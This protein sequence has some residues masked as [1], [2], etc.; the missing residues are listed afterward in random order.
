MHI[1]HDASRGLD[2]RIA[3]PQD[4]YLQQYFSDVAS[5]LRVGP[6]VSF[7]VK[8]INITST[9]YIQRHGTSSNTIMNKNNT[10]LDDDG[11][12]DVDKICSIAGC[13]ED[14]L[15]NRISYA[16]RRPW[17]SF[18]ASPA[19][20]WLDDFL[21]W[22]SPEIPQCCRIFPNSTACP[23]PDQPPCMEYTTQQSTGV[24]DVCVPCFEAK[25]QEYLGLNAAT[26]P[27]TEGFIRRLPQFMASTPSVQCSK[28]GM[29][30][31]T[32][33]LQMGVDDPTG[34]AGLSDG[35]IE[36]SYFQTYYVPLSHQGDF[37]SALQSS[38]N[39]AQKA[40]HELGMDIFAYS[41]FHVFFE[42]YLTLGG[43]ALAM[44]G[45]AAVA[46]FVMTL[47]ATGSPWAASIILTM[48]CMICIDLAGIMA[49]T[50]IQANAISLVNLAAAV[51]IGVEFCVHVVH[52]FMEGAG[53]KEERAAV[54]LSEMG[55]SVLTGITMTKLVGVA[56]LATAHTA[57]FQVYF[58]KFYLG[59][60]VLG[61]AHGLVFLPVLLSSVGPDAFQHWS[62]K[63]MK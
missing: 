55:A 57:I 3:L 12:D 40:S 21:T 54:A 56:V 9:S 47:V 63:S 44:L 43:E 5:L 29:G 39:M 35:V 27:S 28:G 52:A 53:A 62:L 46:I 8:N 19:S 32:H 18:L 59:V 30:A 2:Q 13:N 58:F 37:I 10:P 17:D 48:L 42:Q 45:S 26:R 16:A 6:P 22:S 15:L 20:S 36:A 23:P 60:V 25:G 1:Y 31:Y 34:I 49:I 50:G 41:I 61:A 33:A 4:S 7:V 11:L 51:G 38:R 24:C 14:S